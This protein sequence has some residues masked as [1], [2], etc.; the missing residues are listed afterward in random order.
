[1]FWDIRKPKEILSA[2]TQTFENDVENVCFNNSETLS[3]NNVPG[4]NLLAAATDEAEFAVFDLKESNEEESLDSLL[5]LYD[6]T[7]NL[8]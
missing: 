1:M 3:L 5:N 4:R 6:P 8:V 7:R 2:F